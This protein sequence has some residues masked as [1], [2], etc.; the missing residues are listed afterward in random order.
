MYKVKVS[1]YFQVVSLSWTLSGTSGT[2]HQTKKRIKTWMVCIVDVH[3]K[4]LIQYS[5]R[6]PLWENSLGGD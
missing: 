2:K 1:L 5:L 3:Q 4:Q 6:S